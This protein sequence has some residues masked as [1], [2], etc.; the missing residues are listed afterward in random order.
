[1]NLFGPSS[2]VKAVAA[3]QDGGF[4]MFAKV[5]E[6]LQARGLGVGHGTSWTPLFKGCAE[7]YR[8]RW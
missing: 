7:F 3:D 5:G 1:M 2:D 4:E 6:V 8:D